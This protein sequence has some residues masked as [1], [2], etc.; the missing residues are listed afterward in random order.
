MSNPKATGLRR[1]LSVYLLSYAVITHGLLIVFATL[2]EQVRIDRV[3]PHVVLHHAYGVAPLFIGIT[4]IYIGLHLLRQK[5]TAWS[6]AV[7][8]YGFLLVFGLFRVAL[9]PRFDFLLA[10][11]L[12]DTLAAALM[13]TLLLLAR[14]QFTVK[15]DIRS[16]GV[17]LRIAI[18]VL[19]VALLYGVSGFMLMDRA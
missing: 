12:R 16:F 18:I 11:P 4:L 8:V 3:R 14:K 13:V 10:L 17:S 1:G 5:R 6:I 9:G 15:S 2:V 7:G 19:A